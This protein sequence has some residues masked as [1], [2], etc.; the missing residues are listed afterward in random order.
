MPVTVDFSFLC[1][2]KA[3]ACVNVTGK[4][5]KN[6]VF[7]TNFTFTVKKLH[8]LFLLEINGSEELSQ[9]SDPPQSEIRAK[10]TEALKQ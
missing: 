8:F 9:L 6:L 5:M 4:E 2:T 7:Q 1:L 10:I 3:W